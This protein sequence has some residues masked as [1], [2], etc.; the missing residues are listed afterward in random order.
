MA[1]P[2]EGKAAVVT[3]SGRGI[4]RGIAK[5]FAA[6]G[7]SVVVCDFG[8]ALDGTGG[9]Q[10]PA[11]EV[12][13]EI[14]DAGGAA[15]PCY[16][17]VAIME[18][19][20]RI[21][22]TCVDNFGKIDILVTVAGI[23]RDRMVFNMTEEE[24]DAV[25]AVHLKGTFTCVKY[26]SILMRQQRSGRIVT[27][28]SSSGVMGTT[29]QTN[30]GAAKAG[31]AGLT[32][33]VARDLGKY[34]VTVNS[35]LPS[36]ETRMTLTEEVRKAREIR[37]AQGLPEWEAEGP[38]HPDDIAPFIVF[39]ASDKASNVNGQTF[40]VRGNI[41]AL[42]SQPRIIAAVTK[43]GRWTVDELIDQAPRTL[44]KGVVN[45]YQPKTEKAAAG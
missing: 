28:S 18:G 38:Q 23:L 31:I 13:K 36:A 12:V 5:A 37:I 39:L 14:K 4:G 41:I 34:G 43:E 7:A 20:E 9:G 33:V 45:E 42:V 29:G 25:I 11:D 8:G 16:E 40:A 17:N 24:W 21:I 19:G 6:A 27:F 35:I 26:A 15:V 10:T 30:Y 44:G 2:L 1:Q 32:K 22:Q 3:G